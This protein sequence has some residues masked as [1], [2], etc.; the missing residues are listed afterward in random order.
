MGT[1]S[2]KRTA[3]SSHLQEKETDGQTDPCPSFPVGDLAGFGEGAREKAPR[4]DPASPA[5]TRPRGTPSPRTQ[6][7]SGP[8][9]ERSG[10]RG[11][12]G[13]AGSTTAWRP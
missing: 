6:A 11:S 13:P 7:V 3:F 12:N 9:R 5:E 8:S 10:N 2:T 4:T 1:P